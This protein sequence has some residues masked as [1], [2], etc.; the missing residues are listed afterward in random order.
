[1]SRLNLRIVI[2]NSLSYFR[3]NIFVIH[4]YFFNS[5]FLVNKN[6]RGLAGNEKTEAI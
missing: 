6:F 2:I 5:I 4:L 1:M 3:T